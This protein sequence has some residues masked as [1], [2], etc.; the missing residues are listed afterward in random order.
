MIFGKRI[1]KDLRRRDGIKNAVGIQNNGSMG[2]IKS[3]G[4]DDAK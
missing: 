3:R 1:K 4:R 2:F